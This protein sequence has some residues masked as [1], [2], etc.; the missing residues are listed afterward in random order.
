MGGAGVRVPT[1]GPGQCDLNVPPA[2]KEGA[3]RLSSLLA[4]VWGRGDWGVAELESSQL[5]NI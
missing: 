2:P 1:C 3:T 5:T 4:Q